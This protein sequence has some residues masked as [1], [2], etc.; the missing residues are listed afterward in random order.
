MAK[1][2]LAGK[3]AP[4][5]DLAGI[6]MASSPV[7]FSA[8]SDAFA[9][10][11]GAGAISAAEGLYGGANVAAASGGSGGGRLDA[12]RQAVAGELENYEI[13][14]SIEAAT[15]IRKLDQLA[16]LGA[17]LSVSLL[18]G[19][20]AR[21]WCAVVALAYPAHATLSMLSRKDTTRGQVARWMTYWLSV[22]FMVVLEQSL[23]A[24]LL[25]VVPFYFPFKFGFLLWSQSPQKK[26]SMY[27]YTH[28]LAPFLKRHDAAPPG[29]RGR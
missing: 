19:L 9:E 27:V 25:R 2:L 12:L 17:A 7:G 8:D 20:G 23:G 21:H 10:A 18:L 13:L 16:W 15:G 3:A 22:A 14:S 28:I 1:G 29:T 11:G 4:R 24:T 26:G 6:S 5:T